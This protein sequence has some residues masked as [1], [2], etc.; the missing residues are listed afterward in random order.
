MKVY[1]ITYLGP[2]FVSHFEKLKHLL[3]C[4]KFYVRYTFAG[5]SISSIPQLMFLVSIYK[6]E[7]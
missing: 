7:K 4:I 1:D 3:C 2:F 5:K 6:I